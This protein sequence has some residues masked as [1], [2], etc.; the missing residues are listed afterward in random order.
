[1]WFREKVQALPWGVCVSVS[2]PSPPPYTGN[3]VEDFFAKLSRRRLKQG[4]FGSVVELQAAINRFIAEHNEVEAKPFVW[5]ADPDTIIAADTED[6]KRWRRPANAHA[7]RF[8]RPDRTWIT[9]VSSP[10]L[11]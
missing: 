8:G 11:T 1:M 2:F 6:S 4:V 5:R 7:A 3:A 9:A 10:Q